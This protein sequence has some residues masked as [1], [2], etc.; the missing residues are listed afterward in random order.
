MQT[1]RIVPAVPFIISWILICAEVLQAHSG[2]RQKSL[3]EKERETPFSSSLRI[4]INFSERILHPF[5]F[6]LR[7]DYAT[8]NVL[9]ATRVDWNVFRLPFLR[10]NAKS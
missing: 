10:P 1:K 7:A 9:F 2:K 6:W 4:N 5:F 3:R 8:V